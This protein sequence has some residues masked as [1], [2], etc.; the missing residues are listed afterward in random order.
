MCVAQVC[1]GG[2]RIAWICL[3]RHGLSRAEYEACLGRLMPGGPML[4]RISPSPTTEA[5][6][7]PQPQVQAQLQVQAQVQRHVQVA[8]S[9]GRAS[10]PHEPQLKAEATR[11][12]GTR[13]VPSGA[14]PPRDLQQL[15]RAGYRPAHGPTADLF[16]G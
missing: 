13:S 14:L 15:A 3:L 9:A 8:P 1:S 11:L 7:L 5:V 6:S 10:L 16:V 4:G 2:C 12:R